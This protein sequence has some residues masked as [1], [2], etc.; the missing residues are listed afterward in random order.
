MGIRRGMDGDDGVLWAQLVVLALIQG[1]G[2]VH[3]R[4]PGLRRQSFC[5]TNHLTS[6]SC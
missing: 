6:H 4:G 5:I 1:L 3:R 2:L